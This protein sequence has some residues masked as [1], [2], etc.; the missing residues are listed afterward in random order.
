MFRT[1]LHFKQDGKEIKGE[2]Y[3]PQRFLW[4]YGQRIIYYDVRLPADEFDRIE[5]SFLN[6]N[7][8]KGMVVD[9]LL[10]WAYTDHP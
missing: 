3:K 8:D 10:V 7:S 6:E 1:R 4:D 2:D 9:D 5:I